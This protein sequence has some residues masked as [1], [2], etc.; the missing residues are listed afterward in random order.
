MNDKNIR[1][2][3]ILYLYGEMS[4]EENIL[5][6]KELSESAGMRD[7]YEKE[8][9]LHELF[10]LSRKED[11]PESVLADSRS[12]FRE[13]LR[14]ERSKA[15]FI[16][17]GFVERYIRT[18]M[19]K[20]AVALTL[21]IFGILIGKFVLIE[22]TANGDFEILQMVSADNNS[23]SAEM[24]GSNDMEM[25]DLRIIEYDRETEEIT[26]L[27]EAVSSVGIKGSINNRKMQ[28]VLAVALR[29]DLGP[30][31]R[32]KSVDLLQRQTDDE[33]IIEALIFA[34][35]YDDNPGVRLK[36]A[37]ALSFSTNNSDAKK[38]LLEALTNDINT[39]VR[40]QAILALKDFRDAD[41]M[42]IL[43]KKM[44]SD[45]N[46]Y[47]RKQSEESLSNWKLIKTEREI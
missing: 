26:V 40:I 31:V 13:S 43:K 39:G 1:E 11:I 21:F 36:A 25:V 44:E 46:E 6:E 29:S 23:I 38:A 37:Q 22:L 47:I 3:A 9:E 42:E 10:Y 14:Q 16:K 35:R 27:L 4:K 30:S 33:E 2:K 15:N 32:L 19:P 20:A 17:P 28:Q 7:V 24:F 12:R 34:L 41:V 45:E 18:L 5:F 8:K